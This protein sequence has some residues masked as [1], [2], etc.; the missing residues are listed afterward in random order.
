VY[1]ICKQC[2]VA[3]IGP[4]NNQASAQ[5]PAV[6]EDDGFGDF[7]GGPSSSPAIVDLSVNLAVS[8]HAAQHSA[9]AGS[10]GPSSGMEVRCG[11]QQHISGPS[12]M[13]NAPA[14]IATSPTSKVQAKGKGLFLRISIVIY[15]LS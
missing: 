13:T 6:S 4:P 5:Q 14:T 15:H 11:D 8:L 12:S 7:L 1:F 2:N 9:P 10:T 3:F